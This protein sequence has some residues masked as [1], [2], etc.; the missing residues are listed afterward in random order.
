MKLGAIIGETVTVQIGGRGFALRPTLRAAIG[1]LEAGPGY[2]VALQRL[3]DGEFG[4][5]LAVFAHGLD[6]LAAPPTEADCWEAFVSGY[7]ADDL[8]R[9]VLIL[10]NGGEPLKP[11]DAAETRTG[12]GE[13]LSH[14]DYLARLFKLGT[15]WLGWTADQTLDTPMPAIV[16]AYVGRQDMLRALFGGADAPA[17]RNSI[18]L[19]QKLRLAMAGARKVERPK[20][21]RDEALRAEER[22]AR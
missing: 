9:F 7:L 4:F 13:A 17:S 20:P 19:D 11:I 16:S 3:R 15:G 22:R 1:V 5:T 12:G 18:P 8:A 2:D 6:D 10:A 14:A 21:Q